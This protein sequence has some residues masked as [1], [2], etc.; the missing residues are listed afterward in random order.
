MGGLPG[1]SK[2]GIAGKLP[3]DEVKFQQFQGVLVSFPGDGGIR[4]K[5]F[6]LGCVG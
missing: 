5:N 6:R 4:F 2:R 3:P 1:R